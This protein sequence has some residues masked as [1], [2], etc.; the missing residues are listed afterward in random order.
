MSAARHLAQRGDEDGGVRRKRVELRGPRYT[1][2]AC[3]MPALWG[4]YIKGD[5]KGE[6]R[7]RREGKKEGK[8]K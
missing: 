1:S 6:D 7:K 5:R 4:E 8:G 3:V 2:E